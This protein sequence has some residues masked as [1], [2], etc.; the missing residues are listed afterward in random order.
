[1]LIKLSDNYFVNLKTISYI[2]CDSSNLRVMF[3]YDY[4]VKLNNIKTEDG[5]LKTIS[6]YKYRDF[7]NKEEYLNFFNSLKDT[8][9]SARAS[10]TLNFSTQK[11][12]KTPNTKSYA[13]SHSGVY[14]L[15]FL[16]YLL[17]YNTF[18]QNESL[19]LQLF[20]LFTNS[21]DRSGKL[22]THALTILLPRSSSPHQTTHLQSYRTVYSTPP[23]S[24]CASYH[25]S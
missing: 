6:D 21:K 4:S 9:E 1:M 15:T 7:K 5:H 8:L 22:I 18:N 12:A 10:K 13:P 24:R 23:R 25:I 16:P 14:F 3:I 17:S 20:I 11:L 19:D 2:E